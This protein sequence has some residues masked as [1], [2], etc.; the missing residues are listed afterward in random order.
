MNESVKSAIGRKV[1]SA[2]GAVEVGKV[3]AFV[4]DQPPRHI[5]ALHVAGRKRNPELVDWSSV[6]GFGPDAVI[7]VSEGAMRE[8]DEDRED[9]MA[10]HK[11]DILKA[12]VL[13]TAGVE[14]GVVKDAT[15]DATNGALIEIHTSTDHVV[16]VESIHSLGS[17]AIVVQV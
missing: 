15:F 11:I 1:M 5:T 8:A 12:R 16:G 7:I 13:D 17:Y 6:S 3:K 14:H 10:R 4:V 2:D 9:L